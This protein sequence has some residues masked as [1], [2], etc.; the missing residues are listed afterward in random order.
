M[1]LLGV[2]VQVLRRAM[3]RFA[4]DDPTDRLAVG[5]VLVRG[6]ALW[7]AARHLYEP[8]E[9]A[10]GSVPVTVL[11]EHRVQQFPVAADG[12]VEIAPAARDLH[13]R[14]VEIPG[15]EGTA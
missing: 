3:L 8:P 15:L 7:L 14:L 13:I 1:A 5:G 6:D 9:E 10:P 2:V 12:P 11:A 4:T